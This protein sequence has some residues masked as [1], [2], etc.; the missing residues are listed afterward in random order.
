MSE[1]IE[2]KRKVLCARHG[3]PPVVSLCFGYVHCA[4]CEAQIGDR[5]GGVFDTS[6]YCVVG[7][8]CEVCRGVWKKLTPKQRELTPNP[9]KKAKEVANV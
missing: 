3:H 1:T 9:F 2:I 6:N 4:R 7:H 5:L 8:D